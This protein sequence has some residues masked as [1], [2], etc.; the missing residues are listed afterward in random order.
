MLFV[1]AELSKL[2]FIDVIK[3]FIAFIMADKISLNLSLVESLMLFSQLYQQETSRKIN[4][5]RF[6]LIILFSATLGAGL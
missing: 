5:A 1:F 3:I 2:F 4:S 6:M